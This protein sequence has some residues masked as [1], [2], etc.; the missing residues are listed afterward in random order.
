MTQAEAMDWVSKLFEE[1][2]GKLSP[3]TSRREIAAWDSLGTLTLIAGLDN[4]FAI[5]LVDDELQEMK[6]VD[7][8]L[9]IL[10]KGGA[11]A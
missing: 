10:R 8:I 3:E 4:D 2:P 5:T 11:L 6:K 7:D 9:A 1:E